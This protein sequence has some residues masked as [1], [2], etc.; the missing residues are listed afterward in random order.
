MHAPILSATA[1]E[2]YTGNVGTSNGFVVSRDSKLTTEI[3]LSHSPTEIWAEIDLVLLQ[4][5]TAQLRVYAKQNPGL[6]EVAN[7][8]RD[9]GTDIARFEL[10]VQSGTDHP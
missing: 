4:A 5:L 9:E 8:L 6:A 3:D 2:Q 1:R 10:V 7:P